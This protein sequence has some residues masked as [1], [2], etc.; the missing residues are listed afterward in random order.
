MDTARTERRVEVEPLTNYFAARVRRDFRSGQS[1]IGVIGTSVNRD[2]GDSVTALRLRSGALAGGLDF[3]HEWNERA[4][5]MNGNVSGSYIRGAPS[6]MIATQRSSSR[7]F[8]RPDAD[9]VDVDSQATTMSGYAGRFDIGKRAGTWRGNVA[10]SSTSPAYEINDLGFQTSADRLSLDVNLNYEQ[11]KPSKALRRWSLRVGPDASWNYGGD[12]M[13]RSVGAG[14]ML[15]FNNFWNLSY[16]YTRDFGSLDD[17]LT[18]GGMVAANAAGYG[19]SINLNTDSRRS[20]T[21]RLSFNGGRSRE[22]D[23]R[24]ST[25][26]SVSMRPGANIEF[27]VGPNYSRSRSTAQ[28]LT[29]VSDALAT[30]TYGRRY[31]FGDLVQTSLGIETRLNVTFRPN[32]SLEMYAQ[33]LLS[34]GDYGAIKELQAPRSLNFDTYGETAGT[35]VD[36]SGVFTIDPDGAGAAS[37][38]TLRNPDFDFHSLRGSSVLRWEWRPGSTIYFVWQQNRSQQITPTTGSGVGAFDLGDDARH[39]LGLRPDNVFMVKA[40]FWVSP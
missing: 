35:I 23:W 40:S 13:G 15:T 7:Y 2:L 31:V 25:N 5:S 30:S 12:A 4:W 10:V 36:S 34:S 28:Y 1:A 17:R 26:V 29:S 22:Q 39:V 32:L 21:G 8:Q 19:G 9:Y 37:A 20:Y 27:Q 33:P 16:N 38:F 3:R 11:N 14:G 6:V 24:G 18:R